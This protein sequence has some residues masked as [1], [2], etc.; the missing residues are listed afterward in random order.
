VFN[1]EILTKTISNPTWD[2]LVLFFFL[3]TGFFYGILAGKKK[4]LSVL[5]SLYISILLWNNFPYLNALTQGKEL[6]DAFLFQLTSFLVFII[7]LAILFN[8]TIFRGSVKSKKWW[9][10][11]ILSF[12]EIGLF[13]SA[14]FQFLPTKEMFSFS[15]ITEILFASEKA[16]FWWAVLP[17]ISLFFILR[18]KKSD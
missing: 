11:F 7:I 3:A 14:I 17:L 8:K 5:F 15:P 13:T 9:P 10:V 2:I 18:K 16:F 1:L 6:Q 4:L 12:L